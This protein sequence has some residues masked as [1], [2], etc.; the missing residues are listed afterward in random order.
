MYNPEDCDSEEREERR[1]NLCN[2][3][4]TMKAEYVKP[5]IETTKKEQVIAVQIPLGK[6]YKTAVYTRRALK[7]YYDKNREKLIK[8]RVEKHQALKND[9]EYLR[10]RREYTISYYHRKKAERISK[11][12][13]NPIVEDVEYYD[14]IER[15]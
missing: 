9:E 10:K 8:D 3:G 11:I 13:N 4:V 15:V 6:E 2:T 12:E 1:N 14:C 5:D 7:K